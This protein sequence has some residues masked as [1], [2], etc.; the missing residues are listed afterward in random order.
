MRFGIVEAGAGDGVL[1]R[2]RRFRELTA[3][4]LQ[5]AEIVPGNAVVIVRLDGEFVLLFREQDLALILVREPEVVMHLVRFEVGEILQRFLQFLLGIGVTFLAEIEG[6]EIVAR[7][8]EVLID[9]DGFLPRLLGSLRFAFVII[10]QAQV[11]PDGRILR[12]K[13]GSIDQGGEC[14]R[15]AAGDQ[16]FGARVEVD[17]TLP[18]VQVPFLCRGAS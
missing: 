6:A 15:V 4:L 11:V 12:E 1:D 7:I 17:F 8:G 2:L 10:G 16:R 18:D 3:L 14:V 13:L 5:F 9:G